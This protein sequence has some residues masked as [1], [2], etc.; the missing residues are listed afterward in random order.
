MK[1][2]ILLVSIMFASM[3]AHATTCEH[4]T[5]VLLT[6]G[7]SF[8]QQVVTGVA[9]KQT[10]ICSIT[11]FS[12]DGS[13][14]VVEIVEGTGGNCAAGTTGIIGGSS[15]ATGMALTPNLFLGG[16]TNGLS[17]VIAATATTADDVCL[18]APSLGHVI[19]GVI[20]WTQL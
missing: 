9:A 5:P 3:A 1:I 6:S 13:S 16:A 20:S 8:I 7:N 18:L 2:C 12:T 11:L 4:W 10:R 17:G 14:V 15:A 19:S